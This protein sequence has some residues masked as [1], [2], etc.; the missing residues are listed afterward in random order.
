MKT[1]P[2]RRVARKAVEPR[3][4]VDESR[5]AAILEVWREADG[6]EGEKRTRKRTKRGWRNEVWRER[7]WRDQVKRIK[8]ADEIRALLLE[9]N[10]CVLGRARRCDRLEGVRLGATKSSPS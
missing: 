10:G 2:G 4:R 8:V 5:R 7:K 9:T 3:N 6:G 1:A